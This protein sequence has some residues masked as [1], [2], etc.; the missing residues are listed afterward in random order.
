MQK[1]GY[2]FQPPAHYIKAIYNICQFYQAQIVA[3]KV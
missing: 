3:Q 1:I 2:L